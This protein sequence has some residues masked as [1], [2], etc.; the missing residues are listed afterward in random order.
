MS[1]S[2]LYDNLKLQDAD[3][4]KVHKQPTILFVPEEK[5]TAELDK[6]EI[7][8]QVSLNATSGYTKNTTTKNKIAKFKMGTWRS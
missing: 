4:G 8:L 2:K 7:T 5:S 6:V 3:H 1:L